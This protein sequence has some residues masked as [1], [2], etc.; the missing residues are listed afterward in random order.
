M[1]V[2]MH[3]QAITFAS[4]I[5]SYLLCLTSRMSQA[6]EGDLSYK[7]KQKTYTHRGCEQV[8][9]TTSIFQAK[10]PQTPQVSS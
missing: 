4:Q 9:K 1:G 2:N 10:P 8:I 6:Q 7:K 5:R 3:L